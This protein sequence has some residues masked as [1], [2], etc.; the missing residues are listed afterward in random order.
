MPSGA[1]PL[2]LTKQLCAPSD[3]QLELPRGGTTFLSDKITDS[4][5]VNLGYFSK[6]QL[7]YQVYQPLLMRLSKVALLKDGPAVQIT[8][9]KKS[10]K[11]F[12]PLWCLCFAS[13]AL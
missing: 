4:R 2:C 7:F 9:V 11:L 10:Q 13:D 12:L 1:R 5:V 8:T 6:T 3:V